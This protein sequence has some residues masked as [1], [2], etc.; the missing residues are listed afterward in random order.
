[1][2]KTERMVRLAA[3]IKAQRTQF[4]GLIKFV[5]IERCLREGAISAV[6]SGGGEHTWMRKYMLHGLHV[7]VNHRIEPPAI[8]EVYWARQTESF[9]CE[10]VRKFE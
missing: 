8:L 7:V 6:P 3:K 9:V 10:A 2:Q 4:S 5:Y 1:M